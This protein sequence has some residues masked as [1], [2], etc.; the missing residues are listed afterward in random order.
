MSDALPTIFVEFGFGDSPLSLSPTWQ[1][2]SDRLTSFQISRGRQTEDDKASTGRCVGEYMD[3]DRT[4][5]PNYASGPYY[6]QLLPMVPFRV[7]ATL[8]STEYVIF[9]GWVDTQ[10]AW[11][12]TDQ[13]GYAEVATTCNDGFELL[14]NSY[15]PLAGIEFPLQLTGARIAAILQSGIL[16]A[17]YPVFSGGEWPLGT[18][19]LGTTTPLDL[20]TAALDPGQSEVQDYT[21]VGPATAAQ[22]IGDAES[23]E[24][25]FFFFGGD[26]TPIFHDR[27]Y[28]PQATSQATFTDSHNSDE[29]SGFVTYTVATTRRTTIVNNSRVTRPG[30]IDQEYDDTTSQGEFL[31]RS[32][33]YTTQLTTDDDALAFAEWMVHLKKDSYELLD[34]LTL[35]PGTDLNTWQQ[36]LGREIGDRITII[37]TPEGETGVVTEDYFIEGIDFNWGPGI[38]CTVTWRLS[39]S[40][41]QYDY[42]LAGTVG[43]SEA[44][45]TTRAV[46]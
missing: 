12:R 33:S 16:G 3:D 40:G 18:G 46:Y 8:G 38:E 15:F 9:T 24:P 34:S 42:W 6:G 27:Y 32:G 26:G 41:T 20:S 5:D 44:G 4:L 11:V 37:R 31:V 19:A 28:R 10:D 17:S 21:Y 13:E 23:S 39:A 35:T 43:S 29:A 1:D 2:I 30:G 45:T 22:A 7:R 14:G 25:G 36:A